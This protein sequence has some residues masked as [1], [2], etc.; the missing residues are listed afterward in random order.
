MNGKTDKGRQ[1]SID[2][3]A[4]EHIV[5]NNYKFLEKCKDSKYILEK[6]KELKII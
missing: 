6:S 3:F 5:N 4:H 1:A 2:G